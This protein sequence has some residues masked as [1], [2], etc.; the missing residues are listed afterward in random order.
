VDDDFTS[1]ADTTPPEISN[2]VK[3][4]IVQVASDNCLSDANRTLARVRMQGWPAAKVLF[5]SHYTGIRRGWWV[6]YIGPFPMTED[7]RA[8]AQAAQQRLSDS[9]VKRI[10]PR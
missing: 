5:S 10:E 1:H 2:G 3:G 9:K 6:T 4:Y 7:G 8:R